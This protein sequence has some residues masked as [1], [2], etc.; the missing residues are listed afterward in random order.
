MPGATC[1]A[2]AHL[3]DTLLDCGRDTGHAG[4]HLDREYGIWWA[5]TDSRSVSTDGLTGTT[6]ET[7]T[8]DKLAGIV[9]GLGEDIY[10]EGTDEWSIKAHD[11]LERLASRIRDGA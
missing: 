2:E 1:R 10:V 3:G 6:D 5:S 7:G 4:L 8:L 11:L 9:G